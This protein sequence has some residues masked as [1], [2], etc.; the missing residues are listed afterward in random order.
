MRTSRSQTYKQTRTAT[1]W[2]P[3]LVGSQ[4]R[5]YLIRYERLA[6]EIA[7]ATDAIGPGHCAAVV[8]LVSDQPEAPVSYKSR[9]AGIPGL[10]HVTVEVQCCPG[11]HRA[12]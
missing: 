5:V 8:S 3:E 12:V 6:P 9:L 1:V 10:S 7:G 4:L 2:G 11:D